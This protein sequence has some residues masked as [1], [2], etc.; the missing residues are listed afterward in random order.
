MAGSAGE[1]T[2]SIRTRV[3]QTIYGFQSGKFSVY[4]GQQLDVSLGRG[5][6]T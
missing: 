5:R 2:E 6:Y 4:V 3:P 1:S